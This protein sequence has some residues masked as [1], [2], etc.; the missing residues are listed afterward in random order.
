MSTSEDCTDSTH[1]RS[2]MAG[3]C[4][5]VVYL[6]VLCASLYI[7]KQYCCILIYLHIPGNHTV[8]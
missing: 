2:N 8:R 1:V 5:T 3:G 7:V 6:D 4:G